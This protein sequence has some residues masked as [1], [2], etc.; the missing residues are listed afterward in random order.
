M[1]LRQ[2]TNHFVITV[3]SVEAAFKGVGEQQATDEVTN[4][5]LAVL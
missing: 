3:E 4:R 2:V 5:D 1:P